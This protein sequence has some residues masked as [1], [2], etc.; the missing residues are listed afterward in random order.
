MIEKR[1]TQMLSKTPFLPKLLAA[2]AL[3]ALVAASAPAHAQGELKL[4]YFYKQLDSYAVNG[5]TVMYIL[6]RINDK[7]EKEPDMLEI[8]YAW[9]KAMTE[10]KASDQINALY[11]MMRSD[12]A[13]KLAKDISTKQKKDYRKSKEYKQYGLD[14]LNSITTFEMLI[15]ADAERC[16]NKDFDAA[17]IRDLLAPRYDTLGQYVYSLLKP[18]DMPPVWEDALQAEVGLK[19]RAPNKEL[20]SNGALIGQMLIDRISKSKIPQPATPSYIEDGRWEEIRDSLRYYIKDLWKKRYE[21]RTQIK[22]K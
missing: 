22:L 4:N 19:N 1:E 5:K 16:A 13:H 7:V 12:L 9:A 21:E 11:F 2:L 10:I 8:S 3:F 14:A 20:C 6:S 17:V 15:M 18:S